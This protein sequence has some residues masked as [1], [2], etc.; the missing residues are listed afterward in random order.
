MKA[1]IDW[2]IG[3]WLSAV[4]LGGCAFA[5]LLVWLNRTHLFLRE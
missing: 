2:L 5:V 3:H 4:L 1:W